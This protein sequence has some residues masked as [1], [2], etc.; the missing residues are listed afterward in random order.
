MNSYTAV[1]E[2][3]NVL[4]FSNPSLVPETALFSFHPLVYLYFTLAFYLVPYPIYRL[5]A[6]KLNWETN[7]KSIARHWSDTML[8]LSYG[9]I[10]FIFGNY[11]RAF[12][13]VSIF[14]SRSF[15][16]LIFFFFSWIT[17]ITFYPCLF[18]YAWIAERPYTKTSL[19]NIKSWPKGMWIVFSI[20]VGLVKYIGSY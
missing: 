19:P 13:Y 4:D 3:P 18:G 14:H 6:K 9:L 20:A 16:F 1:V 12:R 17:V 2:E 5:I 8:G 10:L 11:T 7:Q 15:S